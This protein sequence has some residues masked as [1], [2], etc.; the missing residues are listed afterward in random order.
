MPTGCATFAVPYADEFVLLSW[1]AGLGGCAEILEPADL[2]EQGQRPACLQVSRATPDRRP[3]M[4]PPSCRP[5]PPS[6]RPRPAPLRAARPAVEPIAPEHLARAMSLLS[7]LLDEE[8]PE[9][10]TWQALQKTWG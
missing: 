10:V 3:T 9:L 6:A 8:R 1:L 4:R 7:Y 2:R 5:L